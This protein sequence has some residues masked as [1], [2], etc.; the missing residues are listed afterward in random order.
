M[1]VGG[2]KLVMWRQLVESGKSG[3]DMGSLQTLKDSTIQ[4]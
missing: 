3:F 1:R 2:A 4:N